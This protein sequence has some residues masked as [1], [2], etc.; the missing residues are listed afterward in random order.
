MSNELTAG[1]LLC[2]LHQPK[3]WSSGLWHNYRPFSFRPNFGMKSE[4]PCPKEV[5]AHKRLDDRQ[6]T[7]NFLGPLHRW[8]NPGGLS[9]LQTLYRWRTPPGRAYASAY[10]PE[11]RKGFRHPSAEHFLTEHKGLG[12]S[13]SPVALRERPRTWAP[14]WRRWTLERSPYIQ[15]LLCQPMSTLEP[16]PQAWLWG[17]FLHSFS[18]IYGFLLPFFLTPG[19]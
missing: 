9:S 6:A 13:S 18:R 11:R 2:K 5:L 4:F 17:L 7:Q 8:L 3:S 16:R 1:L 19:W 14:L 15:V 12:I 10:L